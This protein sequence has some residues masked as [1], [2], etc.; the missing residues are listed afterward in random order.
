MVTRSQDGIFKPKV[1]LATKHPLTGEDVAEPTCFS[2][3]N[4]DSNPRCAMCQE[5][6]ALRNGTWN[7][8]LSLT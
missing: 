4:N 1:L 7:L 3:A 8:V 6:N 5:I 2:Q